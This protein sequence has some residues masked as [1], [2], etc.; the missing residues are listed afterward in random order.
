MDTDPKPT[1]PA[2]NSND[3]PQP[4]PAPA[5]TPTPPSAQSNQPLSPTNMPYLTA[6]DAA[7]TESKS[8]FWKQ[9]I[10]IKISAIIYGVLGIATISAYMIPSYDYASAVAA[11]TGFAGFAAAMLLGAGVVTL[12]FRTNATRS[13]NTYTTLGLVFLCL[14]LILGIVGLVIGFLLLYVGNQQP[15]DPNAKPMSTTV[16]VIMGIVTFLAAGAIGL[17]IS[18]ILYLFTTQRACQLSSS[19]CF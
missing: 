16:K 6:E 11:I 12:I 14:S 1:P 15:A 8:G 19:K 13:I 7:I 10:L 18:F 3:Q 9:N 17:T 4:G 2:P 5:Q